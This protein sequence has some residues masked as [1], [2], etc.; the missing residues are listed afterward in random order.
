MTSSPTVSPTP[1]SAQDFDGDGIRNT[2]DNCINAVNP[3]QQDADADGAG[4][5]CDTDADNDTVLNALDNCPLVA[6]PSQT[7]SDSDGAGDVCV[8]TIAGNNVTVMPA[9]TTG[10]TMPVAL[11][12]AQVLQAGTSSLTTM[13]SAPPLPAGFRVGNPE[14]YYEIRTTAVFSGVVTVC[15]DYTGVSY[16]GQESN[17]DLY[18][19]E[20]NHWVRTTT[21][22]DTVNN[23]ICG[24]VTSLSPFAI[25][26]PS[27]NFSGFLAPVDNPSTVNTGRAGRTYPVKW[28]LTDANNA[29]VSNLLAVTSIT[30]KATSCSAFTG[31]PTD[32]LETSVTGGTSLRYDS[33]T[34]Q[35][36]YNWSTPSIGC[37]TL[38]LNLDSGQ[39]FYAYFNL[40]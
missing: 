39:V 7:D 2:S 11:T 40:R 30:Y 14:T 31:D 23:L 21:S 27:Y 12:F 17:L 25:F 15:I 3:F 29:F 32:A 28:Q 24:N 36:I 6:N 33:V 16:T 5:A 8:L 35:Y 9:D 1:T 20:G 22:I 4:D 38:F 34:N 13:T 10:G 19:F 37:Y 18:H 26:E